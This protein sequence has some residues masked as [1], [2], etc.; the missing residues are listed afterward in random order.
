MVIV[1]GN[2][3]K[4]SFG[5]N[6]F[7]LGCIREQLLPQWKNIYPCQE[8]SE[9]IKS[10]VTSKSLTLQH[11]ELVRGVSFVS[12]DMEMRYNHNINQMLLE[13]GSI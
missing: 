9:F 2:W 11:N 10:S 12:F 5:K 1:K 6:Y 7:I 8:T 3:E 13:S 4:V